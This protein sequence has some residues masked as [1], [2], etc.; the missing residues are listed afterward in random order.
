M[1]IY[2]ITKEECLAIFEVAAVAKIECDDWEQATELVNAK[3]K[4]KLNSRQVR[5][6]YNRA[7]K[8]MSSAEALEEAYYS[9]LDALD[10][11]MIESREA[12]EKSKLNPQWVRRQ[13][14]RW[15]LILQSL[16]WSNQYWQ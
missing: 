6:A 11:V 15:N 8:S 4:M 5:R 9:H 14:W 7:L 12:W 2:R 10:W 16:Q 1:P 3:L 13:Q